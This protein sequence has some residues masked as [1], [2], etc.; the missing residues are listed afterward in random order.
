MPT[1]RCGAGWDW[2]SDGVGASSCRGEPPEVC[3]ACA[4]AARSGGEASCRRSPSSRGPHPADARS[5]LARGALGA[6][7]GPAVAV[8]RGRSASGLARWGVL[9][10]V[11]VRAFPD[12]GLGGRG[13]TNPATRRTC[14]FGAGAAAATAL[15]GAG[16]TGAGA[17]ANLAGLGLAGL[18]WAGLGLAGL[19][20][21]SAAVAMGLATGAGGGFV[22]ATADGTTGCRS[23]GGGSA[24]TRAGTG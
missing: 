21:G 11:L 12:A 2:G 10:S 20:G 7:T 19:G 8:V 5:L 14:D 23:A 17:A 13:G 16:V 9:G 24:E 6:R 18:G 4:L 1:Y 3:S 22:E 15:R